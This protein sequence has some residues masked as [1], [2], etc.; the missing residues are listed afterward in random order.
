MN[1]V[2]AEEVELTKDSVAIEQTMQGLTMTAV[3]KIS[4]AAVKPKTQPESN[5]PPTTPKTQNGKNKNKKRSTN[6]YDY[7]YCKYC[8][9]D[10]HFGGHCQKFKTPQDRRSALKNNKRCQKCTVPIKNHGSDCD[11]K[12]N[13]CYCG[14]T[15]KTY[16]CIS[17]A[18]Q[19]K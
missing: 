4:Q 18:P 3:P 8:E 7:Y 11:Q 16:L 19:S 14:G 2:T 5:L 6:Y 13:Q 9:S 15:H 10:D 1:K 17:P 12:N